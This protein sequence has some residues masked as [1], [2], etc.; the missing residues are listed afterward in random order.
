[1]HKLL[2]GVCLALA[3]AGSAVAQQSGGQQ[4]GGQ[5]FM[6]LHDALNL[7]SF[8]EPAWQTYTTAMTPNPQTEARHRATD[9]LLP[10][11]ATPRRIALIQAAMA[12]DSVEIKRQGAAMLAFYSQLSPAQQKVFDAQTLPPAASNRSSNPPSQ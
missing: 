8:Q 4:D 9:Q 6:Q 10:S 7:S 11:L 12:Q 3:L 1:M 2:T 5:Q